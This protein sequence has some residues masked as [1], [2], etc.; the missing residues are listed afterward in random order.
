MNS[1]YGPILSWYHRRRW[2]KK[3]IRRMQDADSI[4][5]SHTKSGRTWLRVMISH[6]YHLKYG[7]PADELLQFDNLHQLNAAIPRVFFFR[8]TRIPTFKPGGGSVALP[9][10]K[11]TLFIVRDPRDVAV[12]FYFHIQNR[13]TAQ[14]MDRK[15]IPQEDRNKDLYTF[16]SD[17]KLGVLRIIEHMNRWHEAMQKMPGHRVLK[18]EEMRADPQTVL[19]EALSFLD[20]HFEPEIIAGAVEF[21][22]FDSLARK[23]A[24][25]FFNSDK[26]KSKNTADGNSSKVRRGKVGGY[27]DYFDAR[28]NAVLDGMLES[29]LNPAYGYN[30]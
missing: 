17:E 10:D 29:R 11:K 15:G 23:E 9:T 27:R 5:V 20:R 7:V 3:N 13:A 16:V 4:I 18:Y 22:S 25:G 30:A 8:D 1:T 12:S 26:M 24:D 2:A 14:E 19:D 28:Q 6:A 21:S